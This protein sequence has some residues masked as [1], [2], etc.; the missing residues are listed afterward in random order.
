[1]NEE[2]RIIDTIDTSP[3]L[4]LNDESIEVYS[5]HLQ[6]EYNNGYASSYE[7]SWFVTLRGFK[8]HALIRLSSMGVL[9]LGAMR[10]AIELI[11][12]QLQDNQDV[13]LHLR[14]VQFPENSF[15]NIYEGESNE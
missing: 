15:M 6:V 2:K 1:M 9:V 10:F 14:P 12:F 3:K 5:M 7:Y 13:T 8:R 4:I 11:G